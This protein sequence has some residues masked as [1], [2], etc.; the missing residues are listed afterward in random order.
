MKRIKL[1]QVFLASL[2]ISLSAHAG[3]QVVT[4]KSA[5]APTVSSSDLA[6]TQYFSSSATGGNEVATEHAQLFNGLIG[7]V[8]SSTAQSGE[9]TMGSGNTFTVALDISVNTY[10]YDITGIDSVFGW[11]PGAG[12]RSNQGYGITVTYVDNTTATL[13]DAAHWEPN[14][15]SSYWTKVSFTEASGGVMATGVKAITFEITEDANA[16]GV[17]IAREFDVIG[18]ATLNPAPESLDP[19]FSVFDGIYGGGLLTDGELSL[20]QENWTPGTQ[21]HPDL[22]E[23][24]VF[25]SQLDYNADDANE[26][27]WRIKIGKGG[28]LYSIELPGLGE[29]CSPQPSGGSPWVDDTWISAAGRSQHNDGGYGDHMGHGIH[30]AGMYIHPDLDPLNDHAFYSPL[31]AESFDGTNRSYC[32]MNWGQIGLPTVH[33]P[34]TMFYTKYRQMGSGVLEITYY[35]YNF[36][37]YALD[38]FNFPWG[39][40]RGESR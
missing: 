30:Q 15:P 26:M 37:E 39:G 32:V 6:Q 28:H 24:D 9:V 20:E 31:L 1:P 8:D 10:G 23:T 33:R 3:T 40:V 2:I 19:R 16:G 25:L 7:D 4:T 35:L 38:S 5:T 18:S 14:A 29:I 22:N 27:D 36:G 21:W 17:V 34:D 12:G 13:A 11:N